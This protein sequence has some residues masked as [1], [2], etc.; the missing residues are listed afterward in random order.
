MEIN[1]KQGEAF[2]AEGKIEEA[3]RSFLTVLEEDPK[4]KEAYNNLG[5][6]AF[7]N[8][9]IEKAAEYF[10]KSLKLDPFYKQAVLNYVY[11]L[12]GLNLINQA[13]PFLKKITEKYPDD[14][15][16]RLFLEE[17][18]SGYPPILKI[19]ILCLPGFQSFLGDIVHFLKTKYEVHTC[20]NNNNHE[21][22]SAVRWADIV[23]LEWANELTIELTNR[24][25]LFDGKRVICR[26]H[27]YEA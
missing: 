1:L 12:K 22:E 14:E 19:A 8:N 10:H 27:S 9:Q 3:E 13:I 23:W 7:Q 18:K 2:F 17:A 15:D 5:V 11:L 24:S 6:I 16:L 21:I 25:S 4:N 26:L 20:Y